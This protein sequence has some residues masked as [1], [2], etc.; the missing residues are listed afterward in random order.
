MQVVGRGV[1]RVGGVPAVGRALAVGIH[2]VLR[3]RRGEELHRPAGARRV[4]GALPRARRGGIAS[5][6]ALDLADA[7]DDRPAQSI[8]LRRLLVQAQIQGRDFPFGQ[9][10]DALTLSA[11]RRDAGG[12]CRCAAERGEC[13]DEHERD[14]RQPGG[15]GRRSIPRG[16]L[17]RAS[18]RLP[19]ALSRPV[20]A[21][22]AFA[23]R[24]HLACV[25]HHA[26]TPAH[27]PRGRASTGSWR[28][29]SAPCA[30]PA[31]GR[32]PDA[33][34]ADGAGP[35][36]R[37]PRVRIPPAVT[38]PRSHGVRSPA[39]PARSRAAPPERPGSDPD[40]RDAHGCVP[41][42]FHAAPDHPRSPPAALCSAAPARARSHP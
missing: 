39:A 1:D 5:V 42:R 36:A 9:R 31:R 30:S 13:R 21:Q 20:S 22:L 38:S 12:A 33:P 7:G 15:A 19:S 16:A 32:S 23:P 37:T 40:P 28:S 8:A 27:H 2:S 18:R 4:D 26:A 17:P 10:R 35:G 24:G 6:V 3:P 14:R 29:P 41:G 34:P 25:A 11:R